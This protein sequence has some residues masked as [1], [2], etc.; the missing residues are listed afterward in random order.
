MNVTRDTAQETLEVIRKIQIQTRRSLAHGGGPYY[1]MVWGTVW[2]FGYLGNQFLNPD[3][4]GMLWTALVIPGIVIS[5][6]V[7]R[8]YSKKV[9]WLYQDARIGFF[10]LA[11]LTYSGLAIALTGIAADPVSM[12]LAIALSAMFGYVI[13]GIWLWAPLAWIGIAVTT[14][15][16]AS[17]LLIPSYFCLI[18]ALMGGGT[19]FFSGFY[20]SHNWR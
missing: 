9:R 5:V 8:R 18:M 1:M 20:I 12:S 10:W 15:G 19:L 13:M 4:A 16:I 17:Y 6:V 7:G 2:F 11:L 3:I 14:I